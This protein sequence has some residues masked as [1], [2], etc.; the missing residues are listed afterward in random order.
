MQ[1]REPTPADLRAQAT[2]FPYI[3]GLD[4]LRALAIVAVL[5][6]HADLPLRG[7]F[8]GVEIFFVLS[9]FL[10]TALLTTEWL[11]YDRIDLKTFWLRRARRLLPAL[12]FVL[13]GTLAIAAALPAGETAGIG[14]DAL[15]ALGYVMNWHLVL[16]G[17]SYF[18]AGVRPPLL[19]HLWSLAVEEQFY[20]LWPL[21]CVIGLRVMRFSGLLVG[22]VAL[23]IASF[24]LA[25]VSFEPGADPS[26]I[27]YGTDTR[28][29]GI[30]IGAALAMVWA[31]WRQPAAARR[32]VGLALDI[33]GPVGLV[34]LLLATVRLFDSH[35]LLYRGGLTLVAVGTVLVI[36]ATTHPR[37]RLLP[38]VLAWG[39]L[40]WMGMRSY[41][42]YLWHWPIF[43]VTRP[44]LDVPFD[45]LGLL[46]A[47]IGAVVLLA[48]LSYRCVEMPVRRGAL[49]RLLRHF[50]PLGAPSPAHDPP[51]SLTLLRVAHVP[52]L[53]RYHGDAYVTALR[54]SNI[55]QHWSKMRYFFRNQ[56][57]H[58]NVPGSGT[59]SP[60]RGPTPPWRPLSRLIVVAM[61]LFI[62][63]CASLG[64]PPGVPVGEA[65]F[66]PTPAA[67]ATAEGT[68]APS[69]DTPG[70][71]DTPVAAALSTP[72]ATGTP[73]H[74][75]SPTATETP[76]ATATPVSPV[77]ATATAEAALPP[78]DPELAG[79]LQAVLDRTVADGYIPGAVVAV[80]IP[81]R[82][83]WV[84]ASG[85][86]D[87]AEQV[88]M[89]PDTRVRIASISK[90]FT[91]VVVMQL[92]EEGQL[93]LDD[94][95]STWLPDLVPEAGA[96][97]VR[98][99]LQ[100]TTGLYDY[101]EDRSFANQAYQQPDRIFAPVELV[102]YAARF[103]VAFA[104]GAEGNWDYSSTNY[105]I[106]GMLVE[107]VTGNPLAAEMRQRIFE[108]LGL[109]GTFF[110]PDEEIQGTFASGYAL[111]TVQR[112]VGMSFAFATA[113]L[114]STV[115]DVQTFA[116]ALFAGNL[117]SAESRAQMLTFVGGKGQYNMPSLAYGLGVMRNVLP[118]ER[119]PDQSTVYGHIGGFGG[120]RSA[121]WHA[122]ESG[123]TIALGVNQASTNPN[124][125]AQAV[126]DT[127]LDGTGR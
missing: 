109:E 114:V 106:L 100:H 26:R 98:N 127:V 41:G 102:Q 6:Y 95:L 108:P 99:L 23:A 89:A 10:I 17:Q 97:T 121:V 73:T 96:I 84:G 4:G 52:A 69:A 13:I 91:A 80:N 33:A 82:Q 19:Q 101:L 77:D 1:A 107:A 62:A 103:P 49:G 47:R 42:I 55:D 92:V 78:V 126:F 32:S 116:R 124:L 117:V 35:P 59:S 72:T 28:A 94:Q 50:R 11:Q 64:A 63:A 56:S 75:P 86:A 111:T 125:L 25:A 79:A 2:R 24:A 61:M 57:I 22:T 44:S 122:P 45:G 71:A 15:A 68:G 105:V 21:I 58:P 65:T 9:G 119:S 43:Q 110:L 3:P 18:D 115:E 90:M 12:F 87:R 16:S 20:L 27:Y 31:P 7:G 39:P 67:V 113:N 83:T 40:R 66:T 104:P 46:A 5:L 29:S 93:G 118:V 76:T 54:I 14:G 48:E 112:N 38:A 88:Q 74:S 30:L 53:S 120:F 34:G 37:A 85:V 123:I 81:G 36:A 51:A 8:L 70:P 60:E